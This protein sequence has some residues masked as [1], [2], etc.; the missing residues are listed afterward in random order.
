[1]KIVSH[2]GHAYPR[3]VESSPVALDS[4]L[5]GDPKYMMCPCGSRK[6]IMFIIFKAGAND[7][8]LL[9]IHLCHVFIIDSSFDL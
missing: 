5:P 4:A 7:F 6:L 3:R 1:M 9:S 2:P 8:P